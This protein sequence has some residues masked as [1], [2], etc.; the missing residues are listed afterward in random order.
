[1]KFLE[2]AYHTTSVSE[3]CKT[4]IFS[5]MPIKNPKLR[6]KL[7][8]FIKKIASLLKYFFFEKGAVVIEKMDAIKITL[9]HLLS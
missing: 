4:S 5:K 8:S 7:T 9:K 1:M 3:T 2:N 6:K